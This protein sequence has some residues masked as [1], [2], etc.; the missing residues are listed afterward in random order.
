MGANRIKTR[1]I[2]TLTIPNPTERTGLVTAKPAQIGISVL[3]GVEETVRQARN[4]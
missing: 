1:Q 4:Y 3:P 2:S